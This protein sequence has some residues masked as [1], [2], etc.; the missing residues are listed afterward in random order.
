RGGEFN[1][2]WSNKLMRLRVLAQFFAVILIMLA[3]YAAGS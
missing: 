1:R 2:S 3:V